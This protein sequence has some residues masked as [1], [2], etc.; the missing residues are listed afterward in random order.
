M[1]ARNGHGLSDKDTE[2]FF[3]FVRKV[4]RDQNFQLHGF[5]GGSNWIRYRT[6]VNIGVVIHSVVYDQYTIR[7]NIPVNT[8]VKLTILA[9]RLISFCQA[10]PI[11]QRFF[12]IWSYLHIMC[13]MFMVLKKS[14]LYVQIW[15]ILKP[16]YFIKLFVTFALSQKFAAH[17]HSRNMWDS[18]LP[19]HS[20][21]FLSRTLQLLPDSSTRV[22]W[23][24][25][26]L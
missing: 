9:R 3:L 8:M 26:H 4:R 14:L 16:E 7:L 18:D 21:V 6:G 17:L 19:V 12:H 11:S 2:V 5:E 25:G 15:N 22:L 13:L 20:M 23:L 10:F 24:L 1:C